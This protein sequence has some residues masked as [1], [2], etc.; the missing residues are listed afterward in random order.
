MIE[1]MVPIN[2]PPGLFK[3]GTVYDAKGRWYDGF[4]IRWY[5][6]ILQPIGKWR[7]ALNTSG[8]ALTALGAQ[9][10]AYL[11]RWQSTNGERIVVATNAKLWANDS[12]GGGTGNWT[13]ITPAAGYNSNLCGLDTFGGELIIA[14]GGKIFRWDGTMAA[15]A[16]E[17]TGD[18]TNSNNAVVT[19]ERFLVALGA[20]SNPRSVRWADQETSSVWTAAVGNQ[21]GALSLATRGVLVCGRAGKGQTLLFTSTDMW[22]MT[23]IGGQFVYSFR[24]E[25]DKCGIIAPGAAVMVDGRAFWMGRNGFFVYDGYVRQ[26]RCD[27]HDKVFGDLS[28]TQKQTFAE[29]N[30]ITSM[31]VSRFN[32]IWWFYAKTGSTPNCQVIYNYKDDH[33]TVNDTF[34]RIG[35]TDAGLGL[36]PMMIDSA[37][38]TVFEHEHP[39]GGLFGLTAYA[40]SGPFEVGG[41]DQLAKIQRILPDGLNLADAQMKL[42][43]SMAPLDTETVT[44]PFSLADPMDVRVV[45]RQG[46]LRIESVSNSNAWRVGTPRL[47][48]IPSSR[49]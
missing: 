19:P 1:T 32:E 23:Y 14:D 39:L 49:R 4:L 18:P 24:Q 22:S 21:A 15:L 6:G 47:G 16:T 38:G 27:V 43:T 30:T 12:T 29:V 25:G 44:G 5:E 31:S 10:R 42:Y 45:G 46:R 41:G 37:T 7:I 26:L 20:N 9:T 17:V 48:V 35:G 34:D 11:M 40:E 36:A 28:S 33:W 8:Q 3:N 13:D 2:L